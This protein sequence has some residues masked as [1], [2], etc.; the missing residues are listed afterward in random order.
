M[1]WRHGGSRG[2]NCGKVISHMVL[3]FILLMGDVLSENWLRLPRSG[4]KEPFRITCLLVLLE[5]CRSGHY[6]YALFPA[7]I[8]LDT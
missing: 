2:R 5:S 1:G 4:S 6:L 7:L 8:S 3:E